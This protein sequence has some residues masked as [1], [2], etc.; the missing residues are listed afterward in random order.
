MSDFRQR[1]NEIHQRFLR[2]NRLCNLGKKITDH[3]DYP[4]YI[5]L[6]CTTISFLMGTNLPL[7]LTG[8]TLAAIG[9]GGCMFAG[10][11]MVRGVEGIG[12]CADELEALN[13]EMVK[14]KSG[15][16]NETP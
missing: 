11:L 6:A 3:T 12:K 9:L 5:G 4:A 2:Y 14:E 7:A 16:L 15:V 10:F 1:G 8:L 13:K